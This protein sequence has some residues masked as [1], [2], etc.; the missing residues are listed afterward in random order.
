M[1]HSASSN[2]KPRDPRRAFPP[3]PFCRDV[4]TQITAARKALDQG[5]FLLV[6]N[7]LTWR[8]AH[9]EE[10]EAEGN[11]LDEVQWMITK[12]T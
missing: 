4:R 7:E 8:I 5:G 2:Q 10:A 9:P 1:P 3:R 12:L 6:A 11:G